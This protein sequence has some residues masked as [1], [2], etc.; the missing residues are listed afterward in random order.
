MSVR[1]AVILAAGYGTRMLPATKALPKETLPLVDKPVIQYTVEEAVASGLDL[2]IIV[3]SAGK[4]AVEDHFDRSFELEQAL[5]ARGEHERLAEIRRISELAHIAYVR[6]QEQRGIGD[7]ILTARP[8]VGDEPFVLFFPDDVFVSDVP[9][10]R[11]LIDAFEAYGGPMLTMLE[12]PPEEVASYGIAEA[13]PVGERV[14]RVRSL[15]EKPKPEEAP[16][17]LAIVGRY[18]LTPAIFDVLAETPPGKGG[19]IQITDGLALL[20]RR[21]PVFAYRFQGRRYDTGRPLGLLK[22]SVELALQRPDMGPELR[23]YLRGLDLSD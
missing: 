9:V 2:V 18:V 20:L 10:A 19:E 3:T 8:L 21:Q 13:D 17:N 11:Q 16:S 5:L 6:Q 14:Y 7:A 12:V 22:A 15:V 23:R 4:R 1:K